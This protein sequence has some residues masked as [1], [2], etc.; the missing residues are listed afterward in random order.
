[1]NIEKEVKE[2]GLV[3]S[4]RLILKVRNIEINFKGVNLY[5]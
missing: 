1:M 4:L 2:L 5:G 3:N